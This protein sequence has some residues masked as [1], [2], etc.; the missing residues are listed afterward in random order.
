MAEVAGAVPDIRQSPGWARFMAEIGWQI[1]HIG[2]M[3]LYRKSVPLL[4]ALIRIPRPNLP[5]PME[6]I[7]QLA[8]EN[9]AFMVKIEPNLQTSGF[10]PQF[11]AG[12][13]KD[14]SPILPTRT[15]WIDLSL[16]TET[17][18]A[19]LD[20]DTRN[21]VRKA[22][23]QSVVIV[24]TKDLALFYKIWSSN[25]KDKHF[26]VPF[27][28]EMRA[29]WDSVPQK[30]LLIAK[31]GGDVVAGALM[32]GYE[33][34]LYYSFAGSSET[35]RANHAP[36][37]LL[38][39][40]IIRGKKWGYERLDLEGVTDPAVGRTKAWSGFSHFKKGFGGKPVQY[41]GSFSKY[42]SPLGKMFGR[43]I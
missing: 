13:S 33:G 17:L 32:F 14:S 35:G 29:L 43:F 21:L 11:M 27:E 36:Y 37:L 39:E 5:L 24:G 20:K 22:G 38:W 7:D 34:V 15:I 25:A 28:K 3:V 8:L 30:H 19:N 42:Y 41:V 2:T 18:L 31:C 1:D 6:E 9:H 26:Y 12:F 16:T 4:G 23:K 40:A 10:N